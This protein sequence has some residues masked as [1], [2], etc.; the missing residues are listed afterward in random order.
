MEGEIDSMRKNEIMPA[1]KRNQ[2]ADCLHRKR[3]QNEG[4]KQGDI[5]S[6]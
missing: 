1:G 6:K 3:P 2:E 4:L 5:V